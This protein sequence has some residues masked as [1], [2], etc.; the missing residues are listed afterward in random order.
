MIYFDNAATTLI[1]PAGVAEASARAVRTLAD[2]G[3]GSHKAAGKAAEIS[4]ACR[5]TAA[6]LFSAPAPE[7]V[8]FT[9]NAT[10]AL[11]I[12]IKSL[13]ERGTPTLISGYEHNSVLRPL[14][15]VGADIIIASSQPF[16]QEKLLEDFIRG[17]DRRPKLAVVNFVSNV[18]GYIL[19]VEEISHL[20]ADRGVPL[21]VDA[22]QAAGHMKVDFSA[23]NAEFIAMPGHKGLFGP[24][25][26]G[27]LIA[28]GKGKTFMEGGSG[29]NSLDEFMPSF[30]P[31]RHEA[32]T[33][34]MPGISGLY[35][36]L[37]FVERL[38]I[39]RIRKIEDELLEAALYEL[40]SIDGIRVFRARKP[41]RQSAVVSFTAQNL[42]ANELAEALSGEGVAVR[43][44]YHCAPLAHRS[45]GTEPGG[46]VRL[47]FSV[48]NTQ[49][50]IERFAAKL[51]HI[52]K[53]I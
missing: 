17:L 31:D 53:R 24:Q 37:R 20:C 26:T 46:T 19:P 5:E 4:Y 7:N 23:L 30:L 6:R 27:I 10:H 38:G 15:A 16:E 2:P 33:H 44:G 32:G 25:G 36:G 40:E 50:E 52:L 22:S 45:A 42:G 48:F 28:S 8:I 43:A 13:A 14:K 29:S 51:R 1:K 34:N 47:S 18:F 39:E 9:M 12:A 3:R 21:I 49:W 41:G 35:E 11:N